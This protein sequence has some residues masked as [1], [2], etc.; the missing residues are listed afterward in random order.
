[1][2][3]G[4]GTALI[5]PYDK[6]QNIAYTALRKLV[7]YQIESGI[8][9]LVALGTT[10]ETPVLTFDEREKILET[11]ISE[12]NK[13]VPII[14]GTGSNNTKEVVKLNQQAEKYGADALLIVNPYYN[15]GTQ[16]SIV[17][18]Y[19]YICGYTNLPI[20]LY[21]VP[22]RTGM[23]ILPETVVKIAEKCK[24]VFSVKEACSN[25]SQIAELF[26]IIPTDFKV[27]SGND[28]QTLPIMAM[29]GDGVI[30]VFANAYPKHLKKITEAIFAGDY[31][32]AQ[33]FSNAYIKMMNL[34]FIETSPA[35]LKYVMSLLGL[36]ENVL[37]LP[38]DEVTDKTKTVLKQA[39]E[40]FPKV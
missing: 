17:K 8:D 34:M 6:E 36:C 38:L 24:N 14:V 20:M 32:A 11:V 21:N 18:H 33:N 19:E 15:K 40:N 26:S 7:N 4:V 27:F 1:M 37:R 30:S 2:F 23:N 39:V 28:D 5:T 31:K 35:P 13:R 29:G 16:E 22:Y 3:K 25:I 12:N 10:G 9:F